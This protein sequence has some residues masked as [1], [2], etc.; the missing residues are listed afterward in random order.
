MPPDRD[1]M[2]S[3]IPPHVPPE[4]VYDFDFVADPLLTPDPHAGLLE[5]RRRA[6][7]LFFTP[8]HGGHWVA[9]SHAAVFHVVHDPATFSSTIRGY[10]PLPPI[11]FDPP[12]HG[13]YRGALIQVFAPKNVS[14]MLPTIR[15]LTLQLIDK[16]AGSGRCDF[17]ADIAEPLPVTIFMRMLGLPVEQM[18]AFRRAIVAFLKE[19]DHAKGEL[20]FEELLRLI[21]PVLR[22]R[23]QE[24]RDDMISRLLDSQLGDRPPSWDEM[25]RYLLF[26][27]TAGLDTVTN[28]MSFAMRHLA[29]DGALQDRLRADP[30]LIPIAIEEFLRRYAVSTILRTVTRDTDHDGVPLRAGDPVH[31]LIP[32]ANLDPAVFEAPDQVILDRDEPPLTFGAG[33]HRCLGSHLARLELRN[34][35]TEWFARVPP[36]RLDPDDP[37]ELHAGLVYTVDRLPLLW[38]RAP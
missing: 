8:R 28:A 20:L 29:L 30:G 19:A 25:Q 37:P 36:F 16:V 26:L 34:V 17:V 7:G 24:R 27:T 23:Q 21:D 2:E 4:L 10:R 11:N 35:L 6:P 3:S 12:Q 22:A 32:A 1:R 33:I 5:L 13:L 18:P 31:V 14:A 15:E 9:Q 38:D